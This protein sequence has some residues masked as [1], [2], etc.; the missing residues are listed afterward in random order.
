MSS[1]IYQ[2]DQEFGAEL[3]KTR[4]DIYN[5]Y[6]AWANIVVEWMEG[7]GPNMMPWLPEARRREITHLWSTKWAYD[8]ATPWAEYMAYKMGKTTESN[9]TG[10]MLMVAGIPICKA[11]GVWRRWFGPSKKPA[12]FVIGL[13]LIMVFIVFK[14]VAEL[15]RAIE[16]FKI[17]RLTV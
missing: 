7:N 4:P 14:S 9:L 15:G 10:K 3:A 12:G 13:M 2:A 6:R 5:G 8:I 11:V 1:V 17:K 16:Y